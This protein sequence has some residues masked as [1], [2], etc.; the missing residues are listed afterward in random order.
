MFALV[1]LVM[2]LFNSRFRP[3]LTR[4]LLLFV[5]QAHLYPGD[6]LYIP[7]YWWHHVQSVTASGSLLLL[8]LFVVFCCVGADC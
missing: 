3:F 1:L 4:M 8:P 6:L 2:F 7:P 5:V